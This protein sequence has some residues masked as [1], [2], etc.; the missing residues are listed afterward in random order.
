MKSSS[1][2]KLTQI[3]S[4]LGAAFL[5][6]LAGGNAVA[7]TNWPDRPIKLIVAYPPGGPVD[8]SGRVFAKF[9]G[10]QLNQSVIVENRPGASGMIG[11]DAT[12]KSAPD[13]YTLNYV[14]SPSLTISPIVQRSKLFDPRK[15]FTLISP[16]VSYTNILL[17]GSQTTVKTVKELVDYAR[18]N[19]DKVTF[20]SAGFG[21]SNH[22]SAE[23]LKQSTGTQM[24][25]IP[26]K[27]NAPAMVDVISGKVTFMFDIVGTGKA[28][29]ESGRARAL[30]V[31]S[32]TRN[33]SVPTV[34]TMI[35]AG[36]ADY[37]VLGW[38]AVIGPKGL[39]AD[40][41]AKLTKAVDAAKTSKGFT[42]A[43]VAAGYTIDKGNAKD[44]AQQI[45][46]EYKMWES[47]ITKGKIYPD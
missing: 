43:S 27:G 22:L 45:N 28:F 41:V 14:A 25:H 35:E 44:L 42:D 2:K 4:A 47:V 38:F 10:E 23:L 33:P 29:V 7:Q 26:Y 46:R 6:T 12:A 8:T 34:P 19:P 1:T 17:V 16:I 20:G 3:V 30:A 13:G 24:L 31:T 37:E 39:P 36:I 9:L 40:V 32:K 11:A 21:G 18:Q 15:D 5:T